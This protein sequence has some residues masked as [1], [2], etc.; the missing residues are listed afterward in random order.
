M[1][2]SLFFIGCVAVALLIITGCKKKKDPTTPSTNTT[3]ESYFKVN[4][5]VFKNASFPAATSD[6]QLNNVQANEQVLL[7]GSS[8][9]SFDMSVAV[10]KILVGIQNVDGYFEV[11]PTDSRS[12]NYNFIIIINQTMSEE[13]FTL[14]IAIIDENGQ[15]SQSYF[16]TLNVLLAG[17][18]QLQV[19]LS[20][21]NEK[22]VDL[23]LIEPNGCHIYYGNRRSLN[24]GELDVD[25][26]PGCFIDSINNENIFY[27]DSAYIE[28]GIYKVYVDL[29]ENCDPSIPTNFVLSV[30]YNGSLISTTT[31]TNPFSGNFPINHPSNFGSIS[32]LEPVLTFEI[33]NVNAKQPTKKFEP[34]PLTESA[35]LKMSM[36]KK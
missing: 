36:E 6:L 16:I 26:N 1:K 29:W 23:H 32:L 34:L 27:T 15:I 22:D 30:F 10:N 19:S 33:P 12:F 24:G 3:V 21:D 35:I 13:S 9:I 8:F 11:V 5:G 28:P 14:Q 2:K 31:G 17:T 18:G 25:S 7:G 20:F 4:N